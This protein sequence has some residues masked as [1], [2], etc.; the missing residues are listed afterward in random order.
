MSKMVLERE[1]EAL[2]KRTGLAIV[3]APRIIER[4]AMLSPAERAE[5]GLQAQVKSLGPTRKRKQACVKQVGMRSSSLKVDFNSDSSLAAKD[6]ANNIPLK[7]RRSDNFARYE[8]NGMEDVGPE[9]ENEYTNS[10]VEDAASVVEHTE[11]EVGDHESEAHTA[12]DERNK[13]SGK[14]IDL[15]LVKRTGTG[16]SNRSSNTP[17]PSEDVL[18]PI[19]EKEKMEAAIKGGTTE[20]EYS[21]KWYATNEGV[22]MATGGGKLFQSN[23][24][25]TSVWY[26]KAFPRIREAGGPPLSKTKKR[27]VLPPQKNAR[28]GDMGGT[29]EQCAEGSELVREVIDPHVHRSRRSRIQHK[30]LK[31]I[32]P[33][34]IGR[35]NVEDKPAREPRKVEVEKKGPEDQ[36]PW[37]IFREDPTRESR[38]GS[39]AYETAIAESLRLYQQLARP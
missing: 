25:A 21:R 33:T 28:Q 35:S 27:N 1:R 18:K 32:T 37:N 26:P 11:V 23:G 7:Q 4:G 8:D 38:R 31:P 2:R 3:I 12:S 29:L 15:D 22:D 19:T 14:T 17:S 16:S 10:R 30:P 36:K 39:R 24:L 9:A 13:T 6:I 34:N 20:E 5:A